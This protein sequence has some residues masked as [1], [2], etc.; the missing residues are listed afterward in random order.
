MKK[1]VQIILSTITVS[2][3]L[4]GSVSYAHSAHFEK[5][6]RSAELSYDFR[7]ATM[8]VYKWYLSPMGAM[9]KGKMTFDAKTFTEYAEGLER[10]S[11]LDLLEGF[12]AKSGEDHVDDS[13]AKEKVWN[14]IADFEKKFKIFQLEA[15]KLAAT[16][17]TT[18]EAATK[19]QFKK[20]AATCQACHKEYK[21]K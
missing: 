1:N 10:A 12:P 20:T 18:N 11:M 21:N 19:A 4:W 9:V 16:A 3:A 15:K 6:T 8:S 5:P 14:N 7:S 17:K 2:V 13:N